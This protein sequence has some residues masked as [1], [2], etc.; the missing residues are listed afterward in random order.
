MT[1]KFLMLFSIL[2][3]FN[4]GGGAGAAASVIASIIPDGC[5]CDTIEQA[6]YGEGW[7]EI[8]RQ[9]GIDDDDLGPDGEAMIVLCTDYELL[10]WS[11]TDEEGNS[12]VRRTLIDC[13]AT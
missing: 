12:I 13:K 2:F 6:D 8:S 10:R 7:V 5:Q 9:S 11:T 1:K 4:C 3:L